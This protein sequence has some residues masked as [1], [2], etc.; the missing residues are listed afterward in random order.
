MTEGT[1]WLTALFALCDRFDVTLVEFT[2]S[3]RQHDTA[4]MEL[5]VQTEFGRKTGGAYFHP[6]KASEVARAERLV[7][8]FLVDWTEERARKGGTTDTE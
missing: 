4:M 8:Q 6:G 5:T 3:R 7:E 1:G 2:L